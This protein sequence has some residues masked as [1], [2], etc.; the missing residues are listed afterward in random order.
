MCKRYFFSNILLNEERMDLK[1]LLTETEQWLLET[2]S[3]SSV[4]ENSTDDFGTAFNDA[5]IRDELKI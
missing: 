3:L 5:V 2:S 4:D 1:Q